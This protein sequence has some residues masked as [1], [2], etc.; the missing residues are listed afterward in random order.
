MEN[1]VK[2]KFSEAVGQINEKNPYALLFIVIIVV[3]L[4]DYFFVM[5]MQIKVINSL[6][7]RITDSSNE[8]ERT[9]KNIARLPQFK[10]EM[11][12]LDDKVGLINTKIHSKNDLPFVLEKISLMANHNGVKIEE[13]APDR[14]D[15]VSL[16]KNDQ[17]EYFAIPI[18]LQIQSGY[19]QFGAFLSQ[20]ERE[21]IFMQ[22]P[23]FT[24]SDDGGDPREHRI[25]LR[26][27]AVMFEETKG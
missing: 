7:P 19:H 25:M 18:I 12:E 24:I 10:T 1:K 6:T 9:R 4:L 13:I 3:L 21:E 2:E 11:K 27:N 22:I 14:G 8:L 5:R 15:E 20:L 23:E 16:L 26:L 17:G